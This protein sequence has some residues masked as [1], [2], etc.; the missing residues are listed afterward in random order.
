MCAVL[1]FLMMGPLI[2]HFRLGH[3][4]LTTYKLSEN[5][6][7]IKYV[8]PLHTHTLHCDLVKNTGC[9]KK[10]WPVHRAVKKDILQFPF[11][12]KIAEIFWEYCQL[13]VFTSNVFV[14]AEHHSIH[15][16]NDMSVIINHKTVKTYQLQYF[17][18]DLEEFGLIALKL[19]TKLQKQHSTF[20]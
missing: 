12:Q 7:C 14:T 5:Y 16:V 18:S 11:Q 20:E 2:S 10:N 17:K 15:R 3:Q 19:G 13:L 6:V 4:K 9:L 1:S 8:T